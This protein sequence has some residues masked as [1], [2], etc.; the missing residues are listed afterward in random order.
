MV[1]IRNNVTAIFTP[2][3]F[4]ESAKLHK[5]AFYSRKTIARLNLFQVEIH[6]KLRVGIMILI[7][8]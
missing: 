4:D 8:K 3:F 6:A 2:R 7:W 1:G 5:L